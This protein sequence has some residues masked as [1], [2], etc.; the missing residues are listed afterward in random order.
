MIFVLLPCALLVVLLTQ[1]SML[2]LGK[3]NGSSILAIKLEEKY[4]KDLTINLIAREYTLK[5][6]KIFYPHLLALVIFL[7]IQ[8]LPMVSILVMLLYCLSLEIFYMTTLNKYREK[9]IAVKKEQKWYDNNIEEDDTKYI[10][11]FYYN[12]NNPKTFVEKRITGTGITIN[13]AT[14][15]GKVFAVITALI[16]L[17]LTAFLVINIPL[18]F[19]KGATLTQTD[20]IITIEAHTYTN[21]FN[22]NDIVSV[23]LINE[24]PNLIK[25]NGIATN[26]AYLG[27]FYS[28][29][30]GD[31]QLY[32]NREII[33][34]ILITLNNDKSI[35]LNAQDVE[36]TE[37]YY[38]LLAG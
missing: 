26:S 11:G 23:E 34:Y 8:K 36:T 12:K 13:L 2:S 18:D 6:Y 32:I 14:T 4:L 31:V 17:G 7:F 25:T 37:N 22:V 20:D 19:W 10:C 15:L 35:I 27:K 3:S 21:E 38:K 5:C 16:L 1:F 24:L 9:I 28:Q 29:D 30:L 33:S